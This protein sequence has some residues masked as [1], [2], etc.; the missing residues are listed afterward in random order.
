MS[1]GNNNVCK[2]YIESRVYVKKQWKKQWCAH[3]VMVKLAI[4]V[5]NTIPTKQNQILEKNKNKNK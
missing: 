3:G 1:T 2:D 4:K 5:K